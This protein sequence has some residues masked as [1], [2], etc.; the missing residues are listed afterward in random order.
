MIP[1]FSYS[2]Q[3]FE[4]KNFSLLRFKLCMYI[5]QNKDKLRIQIFFNHCRMQQSY[6]S[7]FSEPILTCLDFGLCHI[8]LAPKCPE[9]LHCFV[10]YSSF[11]LMHVLCCNHVLTFSQLYLFCLW[12]CICVK[13]LSMLLVTLKKL[14][15]WKFQFFKQ[16]ISCLMHQKKFEGQLTT[17]FK[18][19]NHLVENQF[20][21]CNVCTMLNDYIYTSCSYGSA[22]I[23]KNNNQLTLK[24][25]L[26]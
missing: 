14:H 12:Y 19:R 16:V 24:H 2:D 5:R 11:C 4:T 7:F 17:F 21:V 9:S 26:Q 22:V 1:L 3:A 25:Y 20:R 6:S 15:W 18:F 13:S 8:W 10:L 23:V